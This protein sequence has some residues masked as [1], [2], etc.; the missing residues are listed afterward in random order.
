MVY[1]LLAD[2]QTANRQHSGEVWAQGHKTFF[3]L[4]SAEH[5]ILN[6]HK[7]ENIYAQSAEHEILNAHRCENIRKFG[8]FQA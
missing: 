6:A 5:E 2:W 7:Y 4:N 1:K 3:M 8:V